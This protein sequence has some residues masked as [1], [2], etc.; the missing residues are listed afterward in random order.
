MPPPKPRKDMRAPNKTNLKKDQPYFVTLMR[1]GIDKKW[2]NPKLSPFE[3]SFLFL[4]P[5]LLRVRQKNRRYA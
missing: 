4:H 5:L 1:K 3:L 2:V